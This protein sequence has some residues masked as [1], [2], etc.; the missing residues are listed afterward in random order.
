MAFEFI[1]G[2]EFLGL[3]YEDF[4]P[5]TVS[6][7]EAAEIIEGMAVTTD[8][9]DT[10]LDTERLPPIS[11]A[12]VFYLVSQK[13]YRLPDAMKYYDEVTVWEA[14]DEDPDE[15]WEKPSSFTLGRNTYKARMI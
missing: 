11:Q 6:I 5:A 2:S 13:D 10:I 12:A 14:T 4:N 15:G 1:D 7:L 9:A 3:N 8:L